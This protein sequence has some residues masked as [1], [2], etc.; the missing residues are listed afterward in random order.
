MNPMTFDEFEAG[1]LAAWDK[2]APSY[3]KADMHP[4]RA[5]LRNIHSL[6]VTVEHFAEILE[7]AF[8]SPHV[9]KRRALDLTYAVLRDGH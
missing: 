7:W 1:A 2:H 4:I 6:G 5:D 9:T 3:V 8:A